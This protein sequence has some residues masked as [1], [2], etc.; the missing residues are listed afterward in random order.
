MDWRD[1]KGYLYLRPAANI[2]GLSHHYLHAIQY[3]TCQVN[4]PVKLSHL[5]RSILS[6]PWHLET[7]RFQKKRLDCSLIWIKIYLLIL[8]ATTPPPQGAR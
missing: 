8:G 1:V 7:F 3:F 6:H 5:F 2:A 4:I